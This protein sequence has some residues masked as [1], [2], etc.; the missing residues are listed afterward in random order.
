MV[1]L[2]DAELSARIG[3]GDRELDAL[4]P[5][6]FRLLELSARPSLKDLVEL[7]QTK[8]EWMKTCL[9]GAVV[10]ASNPFIPGMILSV[11]LAGAAKDAREGERR[12]ITSLQ[13]RLDSFLLEILERLPQTVP[14]FAGG[15]DGCSAV[16]EPGPEGYNRGPLNIILG[17]RQQMETFCVKPIVM[18]FLTRRFTRG[19]PDLWDTSGVLGDT[20][21]LDQLAA[22]NDRGDDGLVIEGSIESFLQGA[23]AGW[24]GLTILPGAQF[25]VAGLMA[26]P[27]SFYRVPVMRMMLDLVVYLAVLAVFS[28]FVL[29]HDDGTM[30]R[31]EIAFA[32]HILV[33]SSGVFLSKGILF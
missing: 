5:I 3:S 2:L 32:V 13:T 21:E 31:G 14:G 19:L 27:N 10:S 26:K 16:F 9:L 8:C 1:R 11:D 18:D 15:M 23:H 29:F 28:T 30:T 20:D 24:P 4:C 6:T 7:S 22:F 17:E 25:I 12:D 33:S